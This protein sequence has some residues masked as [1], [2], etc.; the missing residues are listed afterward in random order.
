ML[1]RIEKVDQEV[2]E[3]STVK[4]F[5][6]LL[7]VINTVVLKIAFIHHEKWYSV[8]LISIPMLVAAIISNKRK[9]KVVQDQPSITEKVFENQKNVEHLQPS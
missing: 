9:R 3:P 7:L 8:L 4:L 1:H 5:L 2:K 6:V